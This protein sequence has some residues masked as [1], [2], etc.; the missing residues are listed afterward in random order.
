M[1]FTTDFEITYML[2]GYQTAQHGELLCQ[3]YRTKLVYKLAERLT[4]TGAS[5]TD[6]TLLRNKAF[7]LGGFF[8]QW[9]FERQSAHP[10]QNKGNRQQRAYIPQQASSSSTPVTKTSSVTTFGESG[11]PM[12]IGKLKARNGC[13]QC[14]QPGHIKRNCPQLKQVQ[15][16]QVLDDMSEFDQAAVLEK[17]GKKVVA[18][19]PAESKEQGFQAPQQ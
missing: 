10:N 14:G 5:M 8:Q 2:A 12:D 11:Q 1:E 18:E 15:V 4:L 6:Y 19:K 7:E 9:D 16:W 13:Y 3:K 17:Y